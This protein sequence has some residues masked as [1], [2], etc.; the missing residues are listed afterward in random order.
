MAGSEQLDK[1]R[2]TP[3]A[4]VLLAETTSTPNAVVRVLDTGSGSEAT[5]LAVAGN[6]TAFRGLAQS[7]VP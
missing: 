4:V 3:T 5:N 2:P 7:P 6:N 1:P